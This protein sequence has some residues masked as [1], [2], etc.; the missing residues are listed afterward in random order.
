M[1][2]LKSSACIALAAL[3]VGGR[4]WAAELPVD[5]N[6]EVRPL[7]A[8]NC[9]TCHG[10]VKQAGGV[11][12]IFRKDV[13]GVGDS[14]QPVVVPGD[15]AASGMIRR[16]KSEDPDEKMPPPEEHP[17]GLAPQQIALLE[18]WVAEGAAW[19]EHWA[20]IPPVA[21]TP[22]TV[23]A[24]GWPRVELDRFVLARLESE[25]IAPTPAAEPHLWLRRV[26]L[27][28]TGLP[29]TLEDWER[30]QAAFA[31]DPDA[32]MAA[33]V[34]GLLASSHFGERWASVWL[35]LARYSDTFGFEKDP[36]RDIWPFR[37]WVIRA[38]NA[39]M[40]FDEFT[41]RQLA[42]DL[43]E[44]PQPGDL[45]ATAFHRNT[46]NNTEGGTDDEEFRIASIPPGRLGRESPSAA[47]SA[48]RIRTIRFPTRI[49]TDSPPS[50]TTLRI[51]I[52]TG[53]FLTPRPP[54]IRTSRESSSVCNGKSGAYG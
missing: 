11:S 50:S 16:I 23:K 24:T 28:L 33:A 27:D 18:R 53:T 40:P 22:P 14:G 49:F 36:H 31:A 7:L 10:G 3:V 8:R 25:G 46:Q 35:D 20:F 48:T 44:N 15:P 51:S 45:L 12:F 41:I 9:T 17:A 26:S 21:E 4:L 5:F 13:L 37:D 42:G 6:R 34:D 30:F 1:P 2:F 39:D 43:L 38:F 52:S 29:P 47:F 54:P 32:A 19:E